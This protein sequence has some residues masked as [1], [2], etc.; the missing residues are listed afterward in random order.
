MSSNP[1]HTWVYSIQHYV[2]KFVSDRCDRSVVFS[3]YS[4]DPVSA[5]TKITD[6]REITEILLK[7]ALNTTNQ[8][9]KFSKAVLEIFVI[10]TYEMLTWWNKW[11]PLKCLARA[12]IKNRNH[13]N[14][15]F[16]FMNDF[17]FNSRNYV[18]RLFVL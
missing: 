18:Y 16:Q 10:N 4:R 12:W 17:L 15:I 1:A 14:F 13:K 6:R 3:G 2:I 11:H 8:T 7:V 9:I 5:S